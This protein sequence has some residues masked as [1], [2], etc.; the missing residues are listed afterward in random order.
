MPKNPWT[1]NHIGKIIGWF[2]FIDLL[3]LSLARLF[4]FLALDRY[5]GTLEIV[6]AETGT[7]LGISDIV[8]IA[9]LGAFIL[10]ILVIFLFVQFVKMIFWGFAGLDID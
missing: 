4:G 8:G 1:E 3:I 10:I 5:H 7:P 2:F 6:I 9:C